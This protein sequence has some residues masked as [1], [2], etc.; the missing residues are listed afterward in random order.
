MGLLPVFAAFVSGILLH[1]AYFIIPVY[2]YILALIL[3]ICS[4]IYVRNKRVWVVLVAFLMFLAATALN[5]RSA[6]CSSKVLFFSQGRKVPISGWIDKPVVFSPDRKKIVLEIDRLDDREMTGDKCFILINL[7]TK[8]NSSRS[9]EWHA[10]RGD[11]ITVFAAPKK[12]KNYKNQGSFD[13]TAELAR[14]G[15]DTIAYVNDENNLSLDYSKARTGL[16]DTIERAIDRTRYRIKGII[17][18]Q[19]HDRDALG[20]ISALVIGEQGYISQDVRRMFASTGIIHILVVAGLHL[21]II[22]HLVYMLLKYLLSRSKYLC[23]HTNIPKLSLLASMIPM[24]GYIFLSGANPPVMR[25]GIMIAVYSFMFLVDRHQ[26][27]W[28]GIMIAA[29]VILMLEPVALYSISFQLSFISVGSI[30]ACMPLITMTISRL[31]LYKNAFTYKILRAIIGMLLVSL[32]VTIGLAGVLAFYFNT[33]PLLGILLNI[34]VIPVFGYGILPLSL[35]S[36]I[37]GSI[38]PF[39]VPW[40]SHDLFIVTSWLIHGCIGAIEYVSSLSIACIRI[41]TPSMLELILYYSILIALI[42]AQRSG[43]NFERLESTALSDGDNKSRSKATV[44][45][46][47]VSLISV[48]V[49]GFILI[50]DAGYFIYKT[51]YNKEL[52]ITFLDVGHG[53]SAFIEFPYGGTMLIDGGGGFSQTYDTGESVVARYIWSLKRS[54]VDSVVS[55]HPQVDHIGGLG[56]IIR[57]MQVKEIYKSDCEP[58]TVVYKNFIDAAQASKAVLHT[59]TA[60]TESKHIHGV[61]V[62]FFTVPH[63]TCNPSSN[64]DINDYPVLTKIT[65]GDVRV[66]FTGDIEK[67]A[68]QLLVDAYESQ[69]MLK[70]T[71]LKAAHHGSRTSNTEQFIDAVKPEIVVISA[72]EGNPFH[73]PSKD[74]LRRFFEKGIQVLRTDRSGAIRVTTN[75]KKVKIEKYVENGQLNR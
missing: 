30:I 36:S 21:G 50:I 69:D 67:K 55:S 32:F 46:T 25:S 22:T 41:P 13:Y 54:S 27:R 59:I 19:V 37:T 52:S 34:I 3:F 74:V 33:V 4:C 43:L 6:E 24:T 39:A 63:D 58:D 68:E 7:M 44:F 60:S 49:P 10:T 28:T 17:E 29:L 64:K 71:I 18:T 70:A 75:G 38:S 5:Y 1:D 51:H 73:H 47:W 15:I 65:Y 26:S 11:Y 56:F 45:L 9:S 62:T 16:P 12:P 40:I 14:K 48:S 8:N 35:I 31:G 61:D 66:L 23:L 2:A 53:D 42:Y 20:I 57:H 72:G